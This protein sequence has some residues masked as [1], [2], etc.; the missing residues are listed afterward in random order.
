MV[1]VSKD[2]R[3]DAPRFVPG[4]TFDVDEQAHQFRDRERR[5]RIVELDSRFLRKRVERAVFGFV[6]ADDVLQRSGNEENL[7]DEA[8]LA[9]DGGFVVRVKHLGDGFATRFFVNRFDVSAFV[10][11]VE[12]E[13]ARGFRFPEA[14]EVNRFCLVADNRNIPRHGDERLRVDPARAEVAVF[15]VGQ[16][17]VPVNRNFEAAGRAAEVPRVAGN[18]PVVRRFDL[19]AVDESLAEEPEFIVDPVADTRKIE[20]CERIKE[21]RGEATEPAVP[22]PHIFFFCENRF[23]IKPELANGF[24][25]N[26]E[27]LGVGEVVAEQAP[28]QI[29]D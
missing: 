14:E 3:N 2:L 18:E 16:L 10:E 5:V 21:A 22:E 27:K 12:I 6:A 15:V 4:V 25:G 19:I 28:H 13:I 20:R 26:V 8:E 17:D 11:L 23:G 7:L 24:F 29:F 9:S 1:R